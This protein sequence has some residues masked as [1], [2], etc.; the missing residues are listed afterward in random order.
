MIEAMAL[1]HSHKRQLQTVHQMAWQSFAQ[2]SLSAPEGEI[3]VDY[4]L[5][6]E[7][8]GATQHHLLSSG[9]Y[10]AIPTDISSWYFTIC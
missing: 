8:E 2:S 6:A 4:K 1:H 10:I 9:E 7:T 3:I 5:K